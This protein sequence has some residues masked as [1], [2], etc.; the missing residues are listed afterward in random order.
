MRHPLKIC[1]NQGREISVENMGEQ[2]L[3]AQRVIKDHLINVGGVAKVSLSK[4][5]LASASSAR[6]R[7]QTYV[8]E[9]KRKQVEQKRW[10]KR[11]AVFDELNDL[12]DQKKRM[13]SNFEALLKS[14]DDLTEKAE[15]TGKVTFISIEMQ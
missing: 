9:E 3:I 8:G 6:R 4:E 11:A 7:Y 12:N 13:K 15:L 1:G 5:L 2:T 10:Q 14:A